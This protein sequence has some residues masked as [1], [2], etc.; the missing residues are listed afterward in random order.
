KNLIYGYKRCAV[1]QR[2]LHPDDIIKLLNLDNFLKRKPEYLSGG[3]KRLVS[4]GRALLANPQAIIMDEPLTNIDTQLKYKILNYI[5]QIP[6]LLNI[7]IIYITH[8]V[9]ELIHIS[10]SLNKV[11]HGTLI[12]QE[13]NNQDLSIKDLLLAKHTIQND[14]KVTIEKHDPSMGLTHV[15]ASAGFFMIPQIDRGIGESLHCKI[16]AQD[17]N[18]AIIPPLM[19]SIENTLPGIVE[20]ITEIDQ[21]LMLVKLSMGNTSS[22]TIW[23]IISKQALKDLNLKTTQQ[24]FALIK[25]SKIKVI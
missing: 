19:T 7:P 3:E 24:I 15:S 21:T 9:D 11:E 6:N 22:E 20:E 13:N 4:L 12:N 2:K 16:N 17:V 25:V 1:D 23:S 5:E 18:L 8:D 10:S 14:L